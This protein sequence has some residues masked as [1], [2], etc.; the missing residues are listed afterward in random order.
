MGAEVLAGGAGFRC[1]SGAGGR[2]AGTAL[3]FPAVDGGPV[4]GQDGGG[5]VGVGAA[6]AV[7]TGGDAAVVDPEGKVGVGPA[8]S[9]AGDPEVAHAD[10]GAGQR[11]QVVESGMRGFRVW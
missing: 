8:V 5:D 9:G 6:G 10:A 2:G 7:A 3:V 1:S 11:S 4:A